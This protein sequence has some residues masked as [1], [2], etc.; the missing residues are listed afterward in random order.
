[1]PHQNA[2]HP[3][4]G[5]DR[6]KVKLIENLSELTAV[7]P[8]PITTYT[9]QERIE[10]EIEEDIEQVPRLTR[11]GTKPLGF[12]PPCIQ[13]LLDPSTMVQKGYR[14]TTR[15]VLG[16]FGFHEGWPV[17]DM[18]QK[19]AHFTED[20]KKSEEDIRGVYKA[21]QSDPTKYNVGCDG[22]SLLR[23]LVDAG[24]TVCDKDQCQFKKPQV[25]VEEPQT[26]YSANFE[27]LVDLVLDDQGKLAFLVKENGQLVVK[28]QQKKAG[29]IL[30]PPPADAI[31]WRLPRAS[32]V[33]RYL[34]N[35]TDGQAFRDLV[36]YHQ[37]ISEL[38]TAN[39]YKFLAA[40]DMHTYL[41]E[42]FQYTPIIWFFGITQ[43]GKS[44]TAKAMTFVSRRGIATVTF[45][46]SHILRMAEDLEATIFFDSKD[47]WKRAESAGVEDVLLNR[48]EY[49]AKVPRV[50]YPERGKFRDTVYYSV[51]GATIFA[52]NEVLDEV[53]ATRTIQITMPESRRDF[54]TDVLPEMGLPFRERLCA[55]RAR[56]MDR[57]LPT[58]EKIFFNRLGDIIRPIHQIVKI[59]DQNDQWLVEFARAVEENR[60]RA[61]ADSLDA[62]VVAAIKDS[63]GAISHGHLFH[64]DIL[65]NLNRGKS[66]REEIT[67]QKLGRITQKLGFEKYTDG[68]RRGI[69]WNEDNFVQL[70]ERFGI[71]VEGYL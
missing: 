44:R 29:V 21:L 37:G 71:E 55:F 6:R 25:K 13:R 27:G 35:D 58:A 20:P 54:R 26:E 65:A 43:R 48:F 7:K 18:V 31:T 34:T 61:G 14:H 16:T 10:T 4:E 28:N 40:W 19:V 11:E 68:Q 46:E 50:L 63:Q 70:C 8:G 17:D 12:I 45:R 69:V 49:G 33:I 56:W 53:L 24:I 15:L 38:P 66:A 36:Q 32:E 51:Y 23:G 59:V 3:P 30:V 47:L 64:E 22:G 5:A 62:Q 1:M 60:K 57:D 41:I 9:A 67:P 2:L 42:K 39:H 52:T